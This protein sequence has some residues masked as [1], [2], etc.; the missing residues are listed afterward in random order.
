MAN[1][2][3]KVI[4]K[5]EQIKVTYGDRSNRYLLTW[6]GFAFEGNIAHGLSF[7]MLMEPNAAKKLGLKHNVLFRHLSDE[8]IDSGSIWLETGERISLEFVSKQ[9]HSYFNYLDDDLISFLRASLW[10]EFRLKAGLQQSNSC[11]SITLPTN[12]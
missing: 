9:F 4:R 3:N 8:E 1:N 12:L 5:G 2:R 7:R 11:F 6:Y 10:P